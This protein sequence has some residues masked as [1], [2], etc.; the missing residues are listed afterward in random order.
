MKHVSRETWG[1]KPPPKGKFD[2][3]NSSRVQGVVVHHSGV[4]NGPKGSAAVQA[5]ERHHMGKG[6]DGIGYN[7][8][9]DESGTIFE[10]RGWESRGAGTK[11]WN[12][13][14]ISVCYTGW[15]GNKPRDEALR[16]LE[17]VVAG[18]EAHFGKGM[19]VSTHRKKA[20]AGYTT[21]PEKWLG[22][23]VE[24]GMGTVQP[25]ETVDWAAIIRFFKDLHEQV[26]QTPLSRSS[27][28]R[29]LPVRLVQGK[30]AERGFD[31]GPVDGVYG[32]KTGDAVREFQKTQGFLKVT[33][34]VNG[35]TFGCLFIQ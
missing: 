25:P 27:R 17:A 6:W 10:G 5:F 26:K 20:K 31:A 13:R 18:A 33:G 2:K 8:L 22:D 9:V 21:C 14:S 16:A 4:E 23:W 24:N 3:L 1:A 15:G 7:W 11:G 12:S 35:E 30:L 28:S 32:K 34:V 19:W 29:G